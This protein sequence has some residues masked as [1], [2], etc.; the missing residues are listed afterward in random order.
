MEAYSDRLG[1]SNLPYSSRDPPQQ[2]GRMHAQALVNSLGSHLGLMYIS[3]T[4]TRITLPA[5]E[6]DWLGEHSK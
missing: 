1:L 2:M 4:K 6:E 5:N 3:R